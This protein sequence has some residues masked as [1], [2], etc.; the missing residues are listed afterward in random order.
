[1]ISYVGEDVE[2]G[3]Y[4]SITGRPVL[5]FSHYGLK[6]FTTTARIMEISMA[7][8]QEFGINLPQDLYILLLY[9]HPKD[10]P[11]YHKNTCSTMLIAD[12]LIISR[13]WKQPEM[14]L[15]KLM[16]KENVVH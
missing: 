1:M 7:I 14:F 11:S 3:K 10:I 4:S 12:L 5:L 13:N 16:A 8:P 2:Q 6:A 9:I 15:N